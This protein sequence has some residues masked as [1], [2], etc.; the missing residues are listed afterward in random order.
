M[1]TD[2]VEPVTARKEK[3]RGGH[4]VHL[5]KLILSVNHLAAR[6]WPCREQRRAIV[7]KTAVREKSADNLKARWRNFRGNRGWAGNI[8]WNRDCWGAS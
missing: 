2:S 3:I 4:Q 7:E 6:Y 8:Q 1:L 5:T